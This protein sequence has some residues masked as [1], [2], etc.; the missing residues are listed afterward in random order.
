MVRRER[1]GSISLVRLKSVTVAVQVNLRSGDQRASQE[2]AYLSEERRDLLGGT[3]WIFPV[4][5]MSHSRK[6]R[7]VE[8]RE[9]LSQSVSPRIREER[10]MLSPAHASWDRYGRQ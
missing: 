9:R 2:F 1:H 3:A 7:Q 5:E 8:I 4:R 10:I 6:A